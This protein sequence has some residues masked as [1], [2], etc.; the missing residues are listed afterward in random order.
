MKVA[1]SE[2]D[3]NGGKPT[4]VMIV[5]LKNGLMVSA[6]TRVTCEFNVHLAPRHLREHMMQLPTRVS[7][8]AV[9]DIA[10]IS[11]TAATTNACWICVRWDGG[12]P[13]KSVCLA[14]QNPPPTQRQRALAAQRENLP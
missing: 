4:K 13:F 3:T 10:S 6:Q 2:T 11:R 14:K 9:A 8:T 7:G 1:N 5:S 12:E